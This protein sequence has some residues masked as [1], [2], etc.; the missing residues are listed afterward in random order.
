MAKYQFQKKTNEPSDE[1]IRSKMDFHKLLKQQQAINNYQ[2]ATQPL[3]KKP[4]F[5][6]FIL[7][8]AV[9]CLVL[10]MEEQIS[11]EVNQKNQKDSTAL[12]SLR[13]LKK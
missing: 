6:G 13:H 8:L 1:T 3:Y 9:V 2:Q 4:L 7:L 11:T 12:D 10:I 5:L